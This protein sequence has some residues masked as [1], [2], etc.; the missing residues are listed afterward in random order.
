MQAR[1]LQQLRVPRALHRSRARV[2]SDVVTATAA[3]CRIASW[4]SHAPRA[5][6]RSHVLF[7]EGCACRVLVIS[8]LSL[9]VPAGSVVEHRHCHPPEIKST[10]ALTR[11]S[12]PAGDQDARPALRMGPRFNAGWVLGSSSVR[13]GPSGAPTLGQSN[14]SPAPVRSLR[15][16]LPHEWG[17]WPSSKTCDP[18][19]AVVVCPVRGPS[20]RTGE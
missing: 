5:R 11:G 6:S 15:G 14:W 7:D 13:S 16:V 8:H 17:S 20:A 9:L 1:R 4:F 2:T 10:A 18:A 3:R 19:R 12:P